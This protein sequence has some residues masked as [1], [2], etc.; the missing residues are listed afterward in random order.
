MFGASAA[1]L[2]GVGWVF[3]PILNKLAIIVQKLAVI[4]CT[5]VTLLLQH[6]ALS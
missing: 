4:T 1:S 6:A 2:G 5:G 3:I